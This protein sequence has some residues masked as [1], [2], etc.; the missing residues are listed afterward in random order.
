MHD[1][2]LCVL[3]NGDGGGM[4]PGFGAH[5]TQTHVRVPEQEKIHL[6]LLFKFEYLTLHHQLNEAVYIEWTVSTNTTD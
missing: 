4:D 1:R 2:L 6:F 5:V 3:V